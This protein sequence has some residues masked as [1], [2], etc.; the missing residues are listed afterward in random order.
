LKQVQSP[1][2]DVMIVNEMKKGKGGK[3]FQ[4][5]WA[6]YPP[7]VRIS[8]GSRTTFT[9]FYSVFSLLCLEC[10]MYEMFKGPTRNLLE[11]KDY[12]TKSNWV[13]DI[14][15]NLDSMMMKAC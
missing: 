13:M 12:N 6:D 1:L 2:G 11:K 7:E 3:V 14:T 15:A 8:L 10:C 5:E 4:D 9:D